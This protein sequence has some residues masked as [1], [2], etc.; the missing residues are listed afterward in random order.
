MGVKNLKS[1]YKQHK[2]L[3]AQETIPSGSV[4]CIDGNGWAYYLYR[5]LDR[6]YGGD[7]VAFDRIIRQQVSLLRKHGMLLKVFWDGPVIYM[8]EECAKERRNNNERRWQNMQNLCTDGEDF[9]SDNLPK[10]Q[11]INEQMTYTLKDLGVEF[12]VCTRLERLGCFIEH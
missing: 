8:K 9:D 6:K 1:I 12:N 5:N 11:L 2:R 3:N 10:P 7:Y 4:L